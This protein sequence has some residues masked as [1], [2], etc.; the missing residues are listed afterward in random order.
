MI[1]IPLYHRG[2]L[3]PFV[4]AE[5]LQRQARPH[6]RV[7]VAL[8]HIRFA[9]SILAALRQVPGA[10]HSID[11]VV[12]DGTAADSLLAPLLEAIDDERDTVAALAAVHMLGH[13]PGP[14][15]DLELAALVLEDTPGF[16]AHA[17]WA[18]TDRPVAPELVGP[19]A[20]AV[21]GGGMPG[22]HAQATLARWASSAQHL[23]LTSL[24]AGLSRATDPDARRDLAETIGLVPGR[25]AGRVLERLATDRREESSVRGAA[26]VAFTERTGEPVPDSVE[27]LTHSDD[28]SGQVARHMRTQRWLMGRG[29]QRPDRAEAGIRIAQID[30]PRTEPS[31]SRAGMGDAGGVATLLAQLSGPLLDQG[32]IAEVV[33]VG[34][35]LPGDV[36]QSSRSQAG[37]RLEGV[38]L[39]AGEG[40]TFSG[41]WPALVAATRG[42]RSAF[43]AGYLPDIV[44]LRMAD[45]GSVAGATVARQFGI[46]IVFTL[47]P[48]PRPHRNG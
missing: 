48:I 34:R 6:R 30:L 44:H 26:I 45:P 13:V 1:D 2:P 46:P 10:L 31:S 39:A 29:P 47:A 20:Q 40:A 14:G 32:H 17:A 7:H 36:V 25:R 5:P 12:R 8:D 11:G 28:E 42:I 41:N 21:A 22:F 23:V 18:T 38:P 3:A 33:S 9:P 15:A 19:L 43:L 35:G 27:R 24:E 37:H 4:V 16:A